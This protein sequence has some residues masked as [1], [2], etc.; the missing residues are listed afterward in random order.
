MPKTIL[1]VDDEPG[2]LT[3]Y[4]FIFEG[5]EILTAK[6]VVAAQEI[7]RQ[8]QADIG[9]IIT[10]FRMPGPGGSGQ[11]LLEWLQ[12]QYQGSPPPCYVVTATPRELDPARLY[13][14]KVIT[15]PF[16]VTNLRTMVLES[17]Q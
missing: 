4:K 3:S 6:E 2:I 5:H 11:D 10:D 16:N 7:V 9:A 1:C 15:K 12:E 14:A 8:C 13:G 17:L